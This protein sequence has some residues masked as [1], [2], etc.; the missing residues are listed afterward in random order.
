LDIG[1]LLV[2]LAIIAFKGIG[3]GYWFLLV[4]LAIIAFKGI[5]IGYWCSVFFGFSL[6]IFSFL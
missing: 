6:D 2:F 5:G 3:I 4:F 1:F